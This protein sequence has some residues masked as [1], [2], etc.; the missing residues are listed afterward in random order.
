MLSY[1]RLHDLT[2]YVDQSVD[3]SCSP[4]EGRAA[5]GSC[6]MSRPMESEFDFFA[7]RKRADRD[8]GNGRGMV[9]WAIA[10]LRC[11]RRRARAE[12]G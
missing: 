2:I 7:G 8:G 5:A 3:V 12:T 1:T 6:Q 4:A 11:R 10:R 9:R